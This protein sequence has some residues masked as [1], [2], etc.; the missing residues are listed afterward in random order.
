MVSIDS[1][2][3]FEPSEPL[4][5][6]VFYACVVLLSLLGLLAAYAIH[7]NRLA[8]KRAR[9]G[10]EADAFFVANRELGFSELYGNFISPMF[11]GL[12]I[13]LLPVRRHYRPSAPGHIVF[14]FVFVFG[15]RQQV[16]E[17]E[18]DQLLLI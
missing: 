17:E 12:L 5:Q 4:H 18:E 11:G 13:V 10:H 1:L 8:A 7:A 3:S 2:R 9:E 15:P 6:D 16:E 14:V